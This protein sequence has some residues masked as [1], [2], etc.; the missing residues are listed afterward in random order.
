MDRLKEAVSVFTSC[1]ENNPFFQDGIIARGNVYMDYGS[2]GGLIYARLDFSN[3]SATTDPLHLPARVNLAYTLQVSGKFMQAWNQF[4][5]AIEIKPTFKPA[6]EGRAIVNLQMSNT[7]AA[8]QD[9]SASIKV[10]PTAELLTNRGVINQFM[11][12]RVNAMKDYQAAIKMDTTY[13]LAYFNAANVYFHTRH[14]RMALDYYGKAIEHNPKDES[15]FLNRAITKVMLRD[16]EGALGDFR[17]A[18]KLSPHTAHMYFNRGN[19]YAS[20]EQF[21]KAEADYSKALSLKPDDALVLKRRADVLGK[22][23]RKSEAIEDY[24]HAIEIQSQFSGE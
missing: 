22:L 15:A 17:S 16:A 18:I 3:K 14:F 12:D 24:R 21:D 13:A 1:I 7:F 2:K 19:L 4:T 9:I 20:M 11:Q 8:Y 10:S 23:G 6:L 5:A